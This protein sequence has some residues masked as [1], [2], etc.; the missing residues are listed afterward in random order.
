[1]TKKNT[2]VLCRACESGIRQPGST[3]RCT[4]CGRRFCCHTS[5]TGGS[6]GQPMLCQ[7]CTEKAREAGTW[8][9]ERHAGRRGC[10]WHQIYEGT[11]DD[12]REACHKAWLLM[13]QGGLRLRD[14]QD[15]VI[16]EV[17]EP[18]LRTRW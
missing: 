5:R 2:I 8:V 14:P 16:L 12:A 3:W 9:V 6:R 10:V 17:A 4:G 11:E 15:W 7:P 13:R 18:T 1:M